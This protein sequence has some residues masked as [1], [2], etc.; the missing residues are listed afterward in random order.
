[1]NHVIH[2]NR[3]KLNGLKPVDYLKAT[4]PVVIMDEPQNMEALLS[5]SAIGDLDPVCTLRYSATHRKTRNVVYR[6]D[7][8][9]A[10]DLNLVKQIVVAEALQ[11]GAETSPY[12]KL[13]DVKPD[14]WRAKL[15]LVCRNADGSLQRR[16]KWV[17][18]D[19]D[20]A[21]VT[22][23]AAYD[24]NWRL[25]E[26]SIEPTEVE[27]TNHGSL[28]LGEEIG[29]NIDSTYREMIRETIREHLKKEQMLRPKGIKVL[30]LF[31]V[32]KVASFLG[33]GTNNEDADGQFAVWFDELFRE[34]RARITSYQ[35]LLPQGPHELRRAYFSQIKKGVFGDTTGT[36]K[37]DDDA[38]DLIMKDKGRLLDQ[39]EPVRFIFS[40]SALREGWDNP[41]VFQIC[42]LREMGGE[43]ERRQTIGRGLRLPINQDGERLFD[44][45][46]A[47]LTIVANESYQGFAQSLQ[48]EYVKAGVSIGVV[49]PA[50]LPRSQ[51]FMGRRL[52]RSALRGP[53]TCGSFS[54]GRGSSTRTVVSRSVSSR[55]TST[56]RSIFPKIKR[57]WSRLL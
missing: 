47:Q 39:N 56:S 28:Q 12:I 52:S 1:M 36:T 45:S 53:L 4:R 31:F 44:R 14:P 10:H 3:D 41:N 21:R 16:A 57:G 50:S 23:N 54:R 20:L 32:D 29:G 38:Y 34:E 7:P 43:T 5:K 17:N 2:Q 27:L 9:D 55:D 8:V 35:E 37:K 26:V 15:E 13:L 11:E 30:S 40:H 6:L 24:N 19:Q 42:T 46:I 49:R 18:R 51:L 48:K 22:G 25:N 33:D